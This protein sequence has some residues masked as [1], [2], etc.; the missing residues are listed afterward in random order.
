MEYFVCLLDSGA[1]EGFDATK[2]CALPLRG[3]VDI[4]DLRRNYIDYLEFNI[5]QGE[6][7]ERDRMNNPLTLKMSKQTEK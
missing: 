4:R 6:R 3:P 2:Y 5:S 7:E 1:V